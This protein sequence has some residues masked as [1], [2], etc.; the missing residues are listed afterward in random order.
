[1]LAAPGLGPWGRYEKG[2]LPGSGAY[3]RLGGNTDPYTDYTA[4]GLDRRTS[5]SLVSL[6]GLD[7][8]DRLRH[9]LEPTPWNGLSGVLT[10]AVGSLFYLLQGV[11]HILE[12]PLQR[13]PDGGVH[14][15][16]KQGVAPIPSVVLGEVLLF[17]GP[18]PLVL[19]EPLNHLAQL[20]AQLFEPRP[21]L[22][23]ELLVQLFVLHKS[24]R[25]FRSPEVL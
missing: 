9:R 3:L 19:L 11:L 24:S 23:D 8:V 14:L 10:D 15:T 13:L 6:L 17:L 2:N 25:L 1:M 20:R 16:G 12:A 4:K 5:L 18:V 7:G 22:L 21:L